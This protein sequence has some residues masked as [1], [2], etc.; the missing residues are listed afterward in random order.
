MADPETL[1]ALKRAYA[2]T[3]LNTTKEAA[4][5]VMFSEKKARSYQQELVTV[6]D[7]ALHMLLRL[8]HMYDSKVKEAEMI[9]LKQQQKVEELEAQLGEAE[10]IVG[11]LR[12][13]LRELRDELKKKLTNGQTHLKS[14]HEEGSCWENSGAAVS[15][16]PE[17]SSSHERSGAIVSCIPAE[18][19]GSV[20]A[21]GTK[22]PSLTRINSIKRCSSR[23]NKDRCH[24]TL[25]SI[26]T[27]R[28]EAEGCTQMIHAVDRCMANGDL[29]SSVEVGDVNDGVCLHK[30]SSCNI[31]ETLKLSGCAHASDSISSVGDGEE[32]VVSENP[33]QK[34]C[35]TPI[36]LKTSPR[37]HE[38]ERKSAVVETEAMKEEKESCANMEVS[39]SP[40]CEEM[41]VLAVNK[42]RCIKYTFKRKR[43]KE[44]LSNLEG[45]SSIEES[46]SRKQKTGEKDDGYLESLKP[47]FT[48]E[49]SRDSLCVAQVARQLV[50]FSEKNGFAAEL[51]NQ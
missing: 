12:M 17:V 5:R 51:V 22:N 39:A 29:S 20:L 33:C 3:I 28:R 23:D 8:K 1:A 15:V 4:A 47:S 16:V 38:I 24:H 35:G 14:D 13:E 48:S 30:V 43:K 7:E 49:S 31:V 46:R 27:K 2:D 45:G 32:V 36:H 18:Q 21:N 34:D 25:P 9:S 40:L 6:R 44:D 26:L 19:S 37:E 41:P 42:N 10:D 50:P 11:E